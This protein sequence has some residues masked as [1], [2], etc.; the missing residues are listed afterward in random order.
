MSTYWGYCCLECNEETD[1]WFNHGQEKLREYFEFRQLIAQSG[2]TF[3]WIEIEYEVMGG[4]W[5][6]GEMDDFL[7]THEDH[8]IA[9]KSEYGD[10]ESL[11]E[12][13]QGF[14]L[15]E[16]PCAI[17]GKPALGIGAVW[18]HKDCDLTHLPQIE[19]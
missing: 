7:S 16:R 15:P 9:L 18:I 10:I 5:A 8:R 3:R 17:C 11:S 4:G 2:K 19:D 1:R 12:T 13:D 14:S 6:A